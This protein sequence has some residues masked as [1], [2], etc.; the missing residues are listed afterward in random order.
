[1]VTTRLPRLGITGGIG[2]GKSTALA[3]LREL[4]AAG[5]SSD[6]VVH[7]LLLD[8]EIVAAVRAHFGERVL[9]DGAVSRPALAHIVFHDREALDWLEELLHPNV[10]RRFEEWAREQEKVRPQPALIVAEVPLLF[11]TGWADSF[12]HTMLITAPAEL[13]RRRIS[14]KLTDSEF[15]RR[16]EQQMPEDEKIARADF[17]CHNTGSRR[18]LKESVSEAFATIIAEAAERAKGGAAQP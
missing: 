10:R 18:D 11:E 8:E 12:D 16:L 6:D 2:S 7:Q 15:A 1:M 13:R 3:Y 17:I 4:G 9:V 14:G 5:I